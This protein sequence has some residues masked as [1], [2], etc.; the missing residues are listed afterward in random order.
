[1]EECGATLSKFA[2]A[3]TDLA[4]VHQMLDTLN[5]HR[6]YIDPEDMSSFQENRPSW[7]V[8]DESLKAQYEGEEG[9][10]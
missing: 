8:F 10:G 2:L 4:A 9:S 3:L 6:P 7:V 5:L 1:M